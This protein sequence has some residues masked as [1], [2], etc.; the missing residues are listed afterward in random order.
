M[1]SA[2]H[3][4]LCSL[5]SGGVVCVCVRVSVFLWWF[6]ARIHSSKLHTYMFI[7]VHIYRSYVLGPR[8]AVAEADDEEE[9]AG[10]GLLEELAHLVVR[11][12]DCVWFL[13]IGEW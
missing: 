2:S 13:V 3:S 5:L 8:D 1:P 9:R 12:C 6:H 10:E 7:Y 4:P 11:M